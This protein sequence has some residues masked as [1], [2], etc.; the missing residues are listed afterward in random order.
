MLRVDGT[1]DQYAPVV[2]T[3]V[4]LFTWT[5][6]A[7]TVTVTDTCALLQ[8]P[9]PTVMVLLPTALPRIVAPCTSTVPG[10]DETKVAR[11]V[12]STLTEFKPEPPNVAPSETL[13]LWN[14]GDPLHEGACAPL[15][16]LRTGSAAASDTLDGN[17]T[18]SGTEA[19]KPSEL[20]V[21]ST[22]L[23]PAVCDLD[24][25]T[26]HVVPPRAASATPA[27]DA[28]KVQASGDALRS[29]EEDLG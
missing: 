26:V 7:D 8:N 3:P 14:R 9:L 27:P 19:V 23:L 5:V 28:S 15:M 20:I 11:Q 21:S 17:H 24:A 22:R 2:R 29:E 1:P 18:R 10:L 25:V 16:A 4:R 13:V 12:A 6:A